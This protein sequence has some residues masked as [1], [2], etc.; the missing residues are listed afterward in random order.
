MNLLKS[1]FL[2]R[3]SQWLITIFV[4]VTVTFILP[5]LLPTDPVERT[6]ST[7]SSLQTMDPRAVESL[8]EAL[9]DLYG[10]GGSPFEQ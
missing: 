9:E 7:L 10:L 1:Y 4:G 2:P 5:R 6:L 8:K 3:L